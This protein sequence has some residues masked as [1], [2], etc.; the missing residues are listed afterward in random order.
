MTTYFECETCGETHEGLPDLVI[1]APYHWNTIHIEEREKHGRLDGETCVIDDEDF[2]VRGV[3]LIPIAGEV[4]R[5]FDGC[6]VAMAGGAFLEPEA[7]AIGAASFCA[8][9]D[10]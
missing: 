9:G 8:F 1:P 4:V 2:F 5:I 3:L 10:Q 6:A 7:G